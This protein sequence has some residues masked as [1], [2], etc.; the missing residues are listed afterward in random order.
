M[1]NSAKLAYA[2]LLAGCL[3]APA[4]AGSSSPSN[5]GQ[6]NRW[7]QATKKDE[8]MQRKQNAANPGA[9]K[10]EDNSWSEATKK[11]QE[12]QRENNAKNP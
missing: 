1:A 7:S 9:S 12:M 5:T 3:T 4:L 6:D 8:E 10:S 11:D 2:F